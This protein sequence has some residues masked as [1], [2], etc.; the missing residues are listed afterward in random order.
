MAS[1]MKRLPL[2]LRVKNADVPQGPGTPEDMFIVGRGCGSMAPPA[3][4]PSLWP[5]P[6][7]PPPNSSPSLMP[8]REAHSEMSVSRFHTICGLL[9]KSPVASSTPLEAFSLR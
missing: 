2:A 3:Q 7:R 5:M 8:T 4:Q 1:F 9:E 6:S